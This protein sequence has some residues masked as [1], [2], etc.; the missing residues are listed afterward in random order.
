[1]EL[2][3]IKRP[4]FKPK[5]KEVQYEITKTTTNQ[6]LQDQGEN[7]ESHGKF[8]MKFI[9]NFHDLVFYLKRNARNAMR[10]NFWLPFPVYKMDLL[11]DY[12]LD[13]ITIEIW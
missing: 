1:M 8:E 11:E 3:S 2:G 6:K 13:L 4:P 12:R 7:E 9:F 10:K 5:P